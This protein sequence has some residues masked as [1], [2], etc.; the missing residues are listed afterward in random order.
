MKEKGKRVLSR[1]ARAAMAASGREIGSSN[2]RGWR[3]KHDTRARAL[4]QEVAAFRAQMLAECGSDR[5]ATRLALLEAAVVTYASIK[6]LEYSVV[7][8]PKNKLLDVTER[9]SWMSSNLSRLLKA[10]NLGAKPRP[11]SL[12]DLVARQQ[13]ENRQVPTQNAS[14]PG[15]SSHV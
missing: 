3:Q 9:V 7:N 6:R 11:R 15:D 4:E 5:S 10:L 2:L 14:I 12:A 13:A 1:K 8:G